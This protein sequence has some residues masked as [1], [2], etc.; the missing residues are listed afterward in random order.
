MGIHPPWKFGA[1]GDIAPLEGKVKL[2]TVEHA[3]STCC[4]ARRKI[5]YAK[6]ERRKACLFKTGVRGGDHIE[7]LHEILAASGA[8]D[9][10]QTGSRDGGVVNV[11]LV[12]EGWMTPDASWL[13]L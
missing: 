4:T 6:G 11:A 13:K 7:W 12:E 2:R 9:V 5:W 10:I 1:F 8:L 3:P